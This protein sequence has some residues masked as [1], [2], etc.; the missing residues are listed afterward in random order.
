MLR[1]VL[2]RITPDTAVLA[3][4]TLHRLILV[5]CNRDD[6]LALAPTRPHSGLTP[7]EPHR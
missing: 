1:E 7:Q 3:C 2:P 5:S 6:F 4:A